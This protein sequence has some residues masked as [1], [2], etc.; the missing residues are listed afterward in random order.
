MWIPHITLAHA[1]LNPQSLPCAVSS[2][3]Y[4]SFDWEIQIDNLACAYQRSQE[5]PTSAELLYKLPLEDGSAAE[6]IE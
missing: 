2:L 4:R 3:P 5:L 1:D 6:T